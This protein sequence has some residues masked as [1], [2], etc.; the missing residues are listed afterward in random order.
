MA[1]RKYP[2]RWVEFLHEPYPAATTVERRWGTRPIAAAEFIEGRVLSESISR[3]ASSMNGEPAVDTAELELDDQDGHFRE[4]LSQSDWQWFR[5]REVT[6]KLL[7]D[8]AIAAGNVDPRI[9]FGGRCLEA[10]P[11]NDRRF[12]M[13]AED[14]LAPYLDR[15]YPQYKFE[16]AYPF[17]FTDPNQDTNPTGDPNWD[18]GVQIPF[19][20]RDHVIPIYY[21]PHVDTTINPVTGV[22]RMQGMVPAHFMGY[23]YLTSGTGSVGEPTPEQAA[24][25]QQYLILG[26]NS[27]GWGGWGELLIGLGDY[28]LPN[29]YI[30]DLNTELPP[31]RIRAGSDRFGVDIIAPGH[32]GWPFSTNTVIRNGFEVTVI[33]ARG[34]VLWHHITNVVKITVDLCGWKGSNGL[35]IDQAGPAWQSFM[36]EHVLAHDGAGYKMN[37]QTHAVPTFADG[38]PM[39]WTSK[40]DEW[41]DL[42]KVRLGNSTGYLISMALTKPTTLR[43]IRQTF[44]QTFDCFDAKSP[45]GALY[46]FAIDDRADPTVG[47]PIRERIELRSCPAPKLAWNEIT[48]EMDYTVGWDSVQEAPR[49]PIINV[50]AQKGIDALKGEVRKQQSP[51][52]YKYTAD[53]ATSVDSVGRRMLRLSIG[54]PRYQSLPL[55]VA[56]IDRSIGE[57]VLVSHR[58]GIGAAGIGYDDQPM[59]ILHQNSVDDEYE[60]TAIDTSQI[61]AASMNGP[62]SGGGL[63]WS[64]NLWNV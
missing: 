12:R 4:L 6:Y 41:Q 59:Q 63:G 49:T 48:T 2:V 56:G 42:T 24:L 53:D 40:I 39:L 16:H 8:Q 33:Y 15:V 58:D 21:G 1:L 30:S 23:T 60:L 29:V 3:S 28:D 43:E 25:M 19:E 50:K 37:P 9:R 46:L 62:I 55:N 61:I 13:N 52:H 5:N 32:P 47:I 64:W 7:S 31:K 34:P 44:N 22:E 18:P 11:A 10:E 35:M 20:L 14:I 27:P 45:E 57:A 51:V 36:A 54:P 17:R 38:R 26:T